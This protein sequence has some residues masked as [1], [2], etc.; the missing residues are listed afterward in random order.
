VGGAGGVEAEHGQGVVAVCA[1]GEVGE[2]VA[3]VATWRENGV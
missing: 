1:G 2:F 3:E